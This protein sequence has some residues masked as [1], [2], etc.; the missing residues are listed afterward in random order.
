ML[1]RNVV[2]CALVLML[3]TVPSSGWQLEDDVE[4]QLA[5]AWAL[6]KVEIYSNCAGA[7]NNNEAGGAGVSAKADRRFEPGELVKIDKINLKKTRIDLYLSLKEPI[8][9]GHMDGPFELFDE[10]VCKVQ[11]M[12][13]L[14]RALTSADDVEG[15]LRL[16]DGFVEKESTLS[17]AQQSASWNQ[18]ERAP[19][20]PDYEEILVRHAVWVAEQTNAAVVARTHQAHRDLD[21]LTDDIRTDEDYLAGFAAGVKDL[22]Y[23][24]ERDC[25]RLIDVRVDSVGDSPPSNENRSFKDGY[26]DGQSLVINL[27]LLANLE[28]CL[29]LVPALPR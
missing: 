25:D 6:V 7:Y 19:Y 8:L 15:I 26:E 4:R 10:A 3:F 20:P 14:P 17:S 16:T 5:G 1:C 21:R 2:V 27:H 13:D 11:L 9:R 23:W 29:V 28:E 22:R 12:I 18:R 24:D